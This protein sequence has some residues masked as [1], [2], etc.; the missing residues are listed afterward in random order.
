VGA[1]VVLTSAIVLA[2][3]RVDFAPG[4]WMEYIWSHRIWFIFLALF[5]A[6]AAMELVAYK[7]H[8]RH[9]DYSTARP[10]DEAAMKRVGAR[11]LALL[12]CV[13]AATFLYCVIF[14]YKFYVWPYPEGYHYQNF[15]KFFLV[16]MPT[17]LILSAPYFWMVER[18]ARPNGPVDEFLVLARCLPR[19]WR[20][21]WLKEARADGWQ[22]ICNPHVRN[23]FIG[24]LVKFFF[25]PVMLVGCVQNWK[26]WQEV[27]R[28]LLVDFDVM[29]WGV[30]E[31]NGVNWL[32]IHGCVL[33]FLF[34]LDMTIA[35]VGYIAS[36]RIF[37]TQVTSAEPT[38]FG[39]AIAL[40]CYP[41]FNVLGG[42]LTGDVTRDSWRI[43]DVSNHPLLFI[44]ASAGI[45]AL[46]AVYTWATFAFGM[47]FSN[48]TNRG[49]ICN[50]PYRVVR[51]PAYICK[52][53]AW[54]IASIPILLI[55]WEVGLL[56]AA[57]LAMVTGVY[58]L[59]A[60]TEER[61]LM[62][63]PHYRE[64]CQKVRWRFIP[65]VY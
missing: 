49:I 24:L 50:G 20:G 36:M 63:E 38:F 25:V 31:N 18:H 48:L 16:A 52:N 11:W 45:I 33:L 32:Q 44:A 26:A 51:H 40:C 1:L 39:W 47:R 56:H 8:R 9:F 2:V 54:W 37:D 55:G 28:R 21:L 62:R 58:F 61:H 41:P 60:I 30:A 14:E 34:T 22:A 53:T 59:R 23:L 15:H 46:L 43:E 4:T 6:M 12:F 3:A 57:H 17:L 65:Y 10:L 7:V 64:Y 35:I 29:I 5:V 42:Y 27:S 19:A 13:F